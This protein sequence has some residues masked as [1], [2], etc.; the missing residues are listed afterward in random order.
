MKRKRKRKVLKRTH[1]KL[2][3]F[4][5]FIYFLA[6]FI[7]P[8]E[9]HPVH[10]TFAEAVWNPKTHSIEIALRVR[11]VDLESA[12]SKGLKTRIDIENTEAW[13]LSE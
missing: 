5:F 3:S 13:E 8:A 1:R 9:A 11:V 7:I 10:A 6:Y 4:N 2:L 12:L